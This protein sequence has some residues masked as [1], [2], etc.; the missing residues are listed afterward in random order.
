MTDEYFLHIVSLQ[1][2]EDNVRRQKE[3]LYVQMQKAYDNLKRDNAQQNRRIIEMQK[4]IQEAE[5]KSNFLSQENMKLKDTIS[6]Q[7]IEL[8]KA[9]AQLEESEAYKQSGLPYIIVERSFDETE[10]YKK[11]KRNWKTR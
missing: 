4:H 9:L 11:R 5:M 3:Q 10:E 8:N 2:Q 1:Q 7:Q 6:R